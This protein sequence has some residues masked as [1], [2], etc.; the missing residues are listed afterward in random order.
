MIFDP[1][2]DG[3]CLGQLT[4]MARELYR[5]T[6]VQTIA[7]RLKTPTGVIEWLR[8]LPQKDDDGTERLQYVTCDVD[9]RTRLFPPDPNCFERS[10]AA[11][12]LLEVLD[13]KTARMLVSI[14]KPLRHTGIVE[15]RGGRWVPIDLFP[16][17]NADSAKIGGDILKGIHTYVGK[18][19]LTFFLGQETGGKLADTVGALQD[20]ALE[21]QTKKKPAPSPAR[22]TTRPAPPSASGVRRTTPTAKAGEVKPTQGGTY[23]QEES[24]RTRE[25]RV[26][27]ARRPRPGD[28]DRAAPWSRRIET[29]EDDDHDYFD[30][31]AYDDA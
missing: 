7:R 12:A 26:P 31:G 28:G 21:S 16:R 5:T 24:S 9:Q 10:F 11:L 15:A 17:R 4:T 1:A 25:Y 27:Q 23:A 29:Q 13:P 14:E 3:A 2:N 18:P 22:P 30:G 20:K 19:L 8:S 6:L